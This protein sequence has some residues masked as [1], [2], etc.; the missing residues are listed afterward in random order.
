MR[1]MGRGT[2]NKHLSVLFI[3]FVTSSFFSTRT[4]G[5]SYKSSHFII[6]SELDP[7]Y[8]HIVQANAEAFYANLVGKYFKSGWEEPLSVY[9]CQNQSSAQDLLVGNGHKDEAAGGY[10]IASAPAMY[11]Y[12]YNNSG[13]AVGWFSLFHGI[14]SHLISMNSQKGSEL[15]KKELAY[16]FGRHSQIIK[17]ELVFQEP[18]PRHEQ[19]S[20]EKIED[21]AGNYLR[22]LFSG[23]EDGA[24]PGIMRACCLRRCAFL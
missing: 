17:G 1:R 10:Y 7:S 4:F 9:C 13:E 3:F 11:T 12:N 21:M 19:I 5:E 22:S 15:F 8:I 14:A 20:I 16:F 2:M 18:D 6:Y 24:D 23:S